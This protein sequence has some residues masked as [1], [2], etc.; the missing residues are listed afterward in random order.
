MKV[1]KPSYVIES[2]IDGKAILEHL[3][4]AI[5]VCYKS[6]DK[7]ENGSAEKMVKVIKAKQHASVLEHHSITIRFI[8]NRGF[9]HEMVRH[10]LCSFSQESTRY[11]NYGKNKFGNEITVI[12]P[13]RFD[14]WSDG[15]KDVWARSME[16]SEACYFAMLDNGARPE[17]ARGV[18]PIDV[19][20]EIVV[21]ANLRQWHHI[22][23]L[24]TANVAHP[25]MR[26]LMIPLCREMQSAIPIIFDDIEITD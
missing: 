2:L 6:E 8:C 3:E 7:I 14:G 24:R 12:Q 21:T 23:S 18:L 26:E 10:R 4:R 25:S 17:D 13:Q 19:K 16:T 5:R 22:F 1:I 20:T 15:L 9:T 11:C